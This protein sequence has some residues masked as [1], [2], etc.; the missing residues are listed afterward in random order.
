MIPTPAPGRPLLSRLWRRARM[1][2]YGHRAGLGNPV[3]A[4][5]LDREYASGEWD[6]FFGP[7]E[8]PRHE[9]LVELVTARPGRFRL[10]DLGCGS[11][12]LASLLPADRLDDYLGVDLSAE[13]LRRARALGLPAPRDRFEPRDF[14]AWTPPAG[15]FD[16]ITFNECLGYAPDPLRTAS[17]FAAALPPGGDL[18]VSH[19][20][21]GNHAEFWRRLS[22]GF[23][24]ADARV[25]ANPDGRAWDLRRLRLSSGV[26]S[27]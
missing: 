14:E 20:R 9:A 15:A 6:H 24:F 10:L 16:V 22:R 3:P 2:L 27:R 5:A 13:G 21:S 18:L 8:L 4:A 17:R 19:F 11:G 12:R 25:V 1:T 23:D 26:R 7:E